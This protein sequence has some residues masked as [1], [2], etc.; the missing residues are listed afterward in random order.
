MLMR[1]ILLLCAALLL[2]PGVRAGSD[3]ATPRFDARY[4]RMARSEALLLEDLFVLTRAMAQENRLAASWLL[5]GAAKGLP[6][7]EYPERAAVLLDELERLQTPPRI[8]EL[9]DRIAQAFRAQGGFLSDWAAALAE[10]RP[11]ESQLTSEFGY[12]EGLHRSQRALF[13]AYERALALFP[14]EDEST[15]HALQAELR[16]LDLLWRGR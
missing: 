13:Q 11:F 9:P 7:D 15:R 1:P 6:F 16:A 4:A 5:S 14:D 2:A 10:G 3:G 8:R 12:H